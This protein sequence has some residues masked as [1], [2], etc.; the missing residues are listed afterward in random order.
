MNKIAKH[1]IEEQKIEQTYK[2]VKLGFLKSMAENGL[3]LSETENFLNKVALDIPALVQKYSL[4]LI[5]AGALGGIGTAIARRKLEKIVDGTE[6]QEMRQNAK[7]IE[8]YKKMLTNYRNEQMIN[9]EEN[10]TGSV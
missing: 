7:K 9:Q 6:D 8:A 3:T 2:S 1:I 4:G 10:S 5:G